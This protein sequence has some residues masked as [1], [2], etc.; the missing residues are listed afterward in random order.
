M[1]IDPSSQQ[2]CINQ[3]EPWVPFENCI[4]RQTVAGTVDVVWNG[5]SCLPLD[6]YIHELCVLSSQQ[7]P[8]NWP[9]TPLLAAVKSPG[10]IHKR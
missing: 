9:V 2:H 5:F 4:V 1:K 7:S 3:S 10:I 6:V 8:V